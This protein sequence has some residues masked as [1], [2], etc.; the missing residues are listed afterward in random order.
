MLSFLKG[1]VKRAELNKCDIRLVVT[2]D[3]HPFFKRMEIMTLDTHR[4]LFAIISPYKC[5]QR[6]SSKI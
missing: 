1:T 3:N 5:M 6:Y 4:Q 2:S